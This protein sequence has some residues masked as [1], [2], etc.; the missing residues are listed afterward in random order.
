MLTL[1]NKIKNL[2]VNVTLKT[3]EWVWKKKAIQTWLYNHGWSCS[4]RALIKYGGSW[5]LRKVAMHHQK[6]SINKV[7]EEARI[8]QG[9]TETIKSYQKAI[10][11]VMKSLTAEEIQEAEALAI[12]WNEQQP[13][14]D[15]Q[16][17][18]TEKKGCK[19]AEEFAKEM[20]KCCGAR[21]VVMVAW[22]DANGE[23]I[24][25]AHDFNDE[26]G[27]SKLFEDLDECWDKFFLPPEVPFKE[28]SRLTQDELTAILEWWQE[29]K[30]RHPNNIFSF[31]KCMVYEDAAEAVALLDSQQWIAGSRAAEGD[32]CWPFAIGKE[33]P[34]AWPQVVGSTSSAVQPMTKGCHTDSPDSLQPAEP[35]AVPTTIK[36]THKQEDSKRKL[37]IPSMIPT[38]RTGIDNASSMR[39]SKW[40]RKAPKQPDDDVPTPSP[41]KKYFDNQ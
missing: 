14:R 16:S 20:W 36:S 26:L 41:S 10:D 29:Q 31:K 12:E 34:N 4:R 27:N 8:K 1:R 13:P 40:V 6:K 11:T 21:V 5:T 25:G 30:E 18:A 37:P 32:T 9:S 3:H 33:Q 19:Y 22:E 39:Q 7:L 23:V 28:P 17:E 24:V 38:H 35:L 2:D 15:V